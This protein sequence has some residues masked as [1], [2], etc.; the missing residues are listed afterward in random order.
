MLGNVAELCLDQYSEE[1][2]KKHSGKTVAAADAVEWTKEMFPHVIRGGSWYSEAEELR[3][4]VRGQTDDWR[5][6]DP[7][8]P[9]SPWWF[10]DEEALMVGFRIVRPLHRPSSELCKKYW[11]RGFRDAQIR[12]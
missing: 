9:K 6:E 11:G 2:Y 3:C 5:I 8:L 10:T 12:C 4:A 7:N 1:T